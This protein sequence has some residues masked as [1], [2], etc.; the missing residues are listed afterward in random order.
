MNR[1]IKLAAV[2]NQKKSSGGGFNECINNAKRLM[3]IK[4]PKV[5]IIFV[6]ESGTNLEPLN[7]LKINTK[8]FKFGPFQ[9][10][11]TKIY[12]FI[13]DTF[14]FMLK[15]KYFSP[16]ELFLNKNDIDLVYFLSPNSWA[17]DLK[18]KNFILTVWDLCHRDE[19]E[20]PEVRND[21]IFEQRESLSSN[22]FVKASSIIVD[23]ANTKQDLIVQYGVKDKRISIIPFKP[24]P[25]LEDFKTLSFEDI[26][27][28]YKI[29]NNTYIFYPAQFW[30]HKNHIFILDALRLSKKTDLK[31]KVVFCG[32]DKG[33]LK[34][35]KEYADFYGISDDTIF[36]DFVP[37]YEIAAFYK[38]A[39]AL[40][41]PSY[42]G[43]SNL[44]PLEA[45]YFETPVIYPSMKGFQ[46]FLDGA[47][48]PIDLENPQTL[49]NQLELLLNNPLIKNE[50]IKKGLEKISKINDFDDVSVINELFNKYFIKRKCW[51]N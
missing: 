47:C 45:L 43:P 33:N 3:K 13:I 50:L 15:K 35:L 39:L 17:Q 34:Y 2:F 41:M 36:L 22:T 44:P 9:K 26:L 21:G 16:F 49:C 28:K 11:K 38:H 42:F 23:T 10:I 29:K 7:D 1:K 25:Y 24:S 51:D 18:N 31:F 4:N 19:L 27:T 48:L 37:D 46:S 5:E 30:P 32:G 8:L 40:V 12:R 20:F 6:A 14:P